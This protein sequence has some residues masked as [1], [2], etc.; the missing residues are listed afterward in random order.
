VHRDPTQG[1][2]QGVGLGQAISRDLARRMG[3]DLTAEGEVGRGAT[4]TLVLPRA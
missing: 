4:S 3:G 1:S 2:A